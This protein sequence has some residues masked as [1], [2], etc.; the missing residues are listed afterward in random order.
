MEYRSILLSAHGYRLYTNTIIQY[1][2][3]I[4][5]LTGYND[6]INQQGIR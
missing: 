3:Y 6:Y 2:L 1:S 4:K 5:H